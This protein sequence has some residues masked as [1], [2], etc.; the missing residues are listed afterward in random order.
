MILAAAAAMPPGA[1]DVGDV[2]RREASHVL[3][4]LLRR[5]D[6]LTDCEDAAQEALA[7]AVEQW[8]RDGVPQS[9]RGW[10]VRV[11]SRRLIDQR[12]SESA[13]RS[14]EVGDALDRELDR[15]TTMPD[16]LHDVEDSLQ[17]LFLCCHPALPP[18]SAVALTLRAVA[19]LTTR[20]VAAALL[21]L[22]ATA[23]QRISR[24]KRTVRDA[25]AAF[26]PVPAHDLPRRLHAVR[27]VLHLMF[28]VGSSLVEGADLV[29][30]GPTH[31]AI[32]LTEQLH[33]ALPGDGESAGLLALMLLVDARAAART[34]DGEL[35]PLAEQDRS[36]WRH[37]RIARAVEILE[38]VLPVGPVGPFQ[39]QAAIAAVHGTTPSFADTDWP[40]ILELYRMLAA[41]APGPAV[42]LG[43]AVAL[44]EV[45]GPE[46]GLSALDPLLRERP[47]DHRVIAARAHLLADLEDADAAPE[48]HR[49]AAL[50]HSIPEQNYL[51]RCA[52]Q[53]GDLGKRG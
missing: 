36:L 21:V 4:A 44:S 45:D 22:E 33:R 25:G 34:R 50:T 14:R 24:A 1:E 32:R 9:P 38:R 46:A 18:G 37:D 27:H 48:F 8:P 30:S 51:R 12:R 10:L 11:A 42:D 31:E 16:D 5:G 6:A 15:P 28:T 43:T 39:L 47:R 13:R 3:A 49:A 29:D 41:V 35:V 52:S 23:A 20:Q 40:Q 17:V 2:W 7:A 19:G 53:T 26:G